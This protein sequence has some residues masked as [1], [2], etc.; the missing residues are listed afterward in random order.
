MA[1]VE[2]HINAS[3][4]RK[5]FMRP[6]NNLIIQFVQFLQ[7]NSIISRLLKIQSHLFKI[8]QRIA[9]FS[10]DSSK[11]TNFLKFFM[12]MSN[13][14]VNCAF[15]KK[16]WRFSKKSDVFQKNLTFLKK[17]WRFSKLFDIFRK[18]LTFLSQKCTF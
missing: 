6:N 4:K 10:S 12:K 17:I 2:T 7:E 9:K 13:F 16:I 1:D 5:T 18:N 3:W 15:L 14:W 11:K 8:N